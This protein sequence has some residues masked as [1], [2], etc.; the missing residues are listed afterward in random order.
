[1]NVGS[2]KYLHVLPMVQDR[3]GSLSV[4]EFTRNIPFEVKRYFIVFNVPQGEVRGEHAHRECHQF[5]LCVNG[6]CS[7]ITDDGVTRSEFVLDKA[8]VGAYLPPM[9]WGV[10]F[11]Y[12]PDAVLLVFASHYYDDADYLRNYDEFA[13]LV[14]DVK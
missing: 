7:V 6:S 13:K 1:M 5:L 2:N 8:N 4:G 10:Q 9:T 11:N 14:K 3:R 12:S